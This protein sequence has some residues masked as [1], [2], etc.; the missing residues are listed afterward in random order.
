M[1]Q[2]PHQLETSPKDNRDTTRY[3][4]SKVT[5]SDD[6]EKFGGRNSGRHFG[7]T[8]GEI[9]H[10]EKISEARAWENTKS[11]AQKER[12]KQAEEM[13]KQ[14]TAARE[15]RGK[16]KQ[17]ADTRGSHPEGS[18]THSSVPTPPPPPMKIH[19]PMSDASGGP[20]PPQ[21]PRAK[22]PPPKSHHIEAARKE[23]E[24]KKKADGTGR[25][26]GQHKKG[27]KGKGKGNPSWGQN[28]TWGAETWQ[29]SWSSH[30]WAAEEKR[31][32]VLDNR[33]AASWHTTASTGAAD[34]EGD[35]YMYG[36]GNENEEIYNPWTSGEF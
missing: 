8:K 1:Q 14:L 26:K 27:G 5:Q 10:D 12:E 28:Q 15:G 31:W 32:N 9:E 3:K 2:D 7:R 21:P 30:P 13:A 19:N 36:D 34:S 29:A 11:L 17:D 25:G 6:S 24:A 4:G 18:T 35:Y 16:G 33:Q 23:E 20:K 22:A